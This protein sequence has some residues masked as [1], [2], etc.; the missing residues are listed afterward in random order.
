MAAQ[1]KGRSSKTNHV[2]SLLSGAGVPTELQAEEKEPAEKQAAQQPQEEQQSEKKEA[3]P[4]KRKRAPS[5]PKEQVAQTQEEVAEEQKEPTEEH[6]PEA[7]PT[8]T[9]EPAPRRT[10]TP[11]IVEVARAN[12]EMLAETIKNALNE[13]LEEEIAQQEQEKEQLAMMQKQKAEPEPK[14]E[15]EP[16]PVPVQEELQPEPLPVVAQEDAPQEEETI[17]PPEAEI[18]PPDWEPSP[19]VEQKPLPPQEEPQEEQKL[20]PQPPSELQPEP[21]PAP[22]QVVQ[23]PFMPPMP[24]MPQDL[25]EQG[26]LPDGSV[27]INVMEL[28]VDEKLERYVKMF[29][30]CD[31]LRCLADAKAL[32]LSRLQAKYVVLEEN[33]RIPM[34]SFYEAKYEEL[35]I[36]EVIHACKTVMEHPRHKI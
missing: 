5:K 13:A 7:A 19:V 23:Q 35:V 18:L 22:M 6:P 21:E 9:V 28:L 33:T 12:N 3:A 36:P 20:E 29:G 30:L 15:P 26:R 17:L 14:L 8:E 31:C 24:Q 1:K 25:H 10:L 16:V 11:P 32:A 4:P 34:L 2:L 27:F